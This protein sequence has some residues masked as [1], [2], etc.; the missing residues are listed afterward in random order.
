MLYVSLWVLLSDCY[1]MQSLF[2]SPQTVLSNLQSSAEYLQSGSLFSE[3]LR[4]YPLYWHEVQTI[5]R[6]ILWS[7]PEYAAHFPTETDISVPLQHKRDALSQIL[8]AVY[9]L[10]HVPDLTLFDSLQSVPSILVLIFQKFPI[11]PESIHDFPEFPLSVVP[12]QL[13][14]HESCLKPPSHLLSLP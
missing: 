9:F 5:P 2:E 8:K 14:L 1:K 4:M 7:L 3:S 13:L 6:W 12:A 11:L 10:V